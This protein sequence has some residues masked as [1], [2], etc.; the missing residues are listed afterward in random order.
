MDLKERIVAGMN[1]GD[2]LEHYHWKEILPKF[3]EDPTNYE[4]SKWY[5]DN[6]NHTDLIGPK[7][8]GLRSL[9]YNNRIYDS[10]RNVSITVVSGGNDSEIYQ[11]KLDSILQVFVTSKPKKLVLANFIDARIYNFIKNEYQGGRY[12]IKLHRAAAAAREGSMTSLPHFRLNEK[13]YGEKVY[14]LL[15]P[16]SELPEDFV[17]TVVLDGTTT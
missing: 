1:I 16:I 14:Y 2:A 4:M 6:V 5:D 17:Q 10:G 13:D 7:R 3:G 15:F 9:N 12:G 11:S 8:I